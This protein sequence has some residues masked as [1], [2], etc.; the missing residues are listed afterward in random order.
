M[1]D[2]VKE[3]L[4]GK[5]G[6]LDFWRISVLGVLLGMMIYFGYLERKAHNVELHNLTMKLTECKK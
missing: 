5:G 2:A 6:W 4:E 1:I 3:K